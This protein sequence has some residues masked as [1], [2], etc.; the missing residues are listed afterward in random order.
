MQNNVNSLSVLH[1]ERDGGTA[2]HAQAARGNATKRVEMGG[3]LQL[4]GRRRRGH[5][6]RGGRAGQVPGRGVPIYAGDLSPF[7]R[8][9]RKNGEFSLGQGAR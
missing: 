8:Q 6:Q 5:E 3:Q 9:R 2:F 4:S 1:C 7:W